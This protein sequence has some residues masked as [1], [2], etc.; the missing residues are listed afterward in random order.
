MEQTDQAKLYQK[1]TG[2]VQDEVSSE[3]DE[4]AENVDNS[5]EEQ[6]I[7]EVESDEDVKEEND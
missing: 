3:D 1:H 6:K 2:V 5:V 7:E 4:D